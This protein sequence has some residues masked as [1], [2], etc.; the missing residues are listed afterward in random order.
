MK[1]KVNGVN[2]IAALPRVLAS[3]G[4]ERSEAERSEAERSAVPGEAKT[5][6][7]PEV[8]AKAQRRQ[9]TADYKR[10]ILAEADSTTESGAIGALLRRE[11]LYS[12]HLTHWRQQRDR[13][14]APHRRGPKPKHDPLFE[15]VRKLKQENGQ[16]TQRL[17]RA[18]LIIDV[19]KK[20]SSLL[21]IP[22]AT[23]DNDESIS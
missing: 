7:D 11:G 13:G 1:T 5:L 8:F 2:G 18:E 9:F 16:L 19:Q 15:E 12:S 21:G 6:P 4:A 23:I 14:L 17:A 10:R 3:P 22:L 20:V